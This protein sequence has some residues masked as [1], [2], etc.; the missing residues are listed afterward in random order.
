MQTMTLLAVAV[1]TVGC[2]ASTRGGGGGGGSEGPAE[3]EGEGPAEG[4]GEGE[5]PAEGEGEGEGP[6]EGEGAFGAGCAGPGDCASG[7]C[8][9]SAGGVCTAPCPPCPEGWHCGLARLVGVQG[10]P[11]RVCWPDPDPACAP[12]MQDSNCGG[13]G[14]RCLALPGGAYC[15]WPCGEADGCPEGYACTPTGDGR[16]CVP[17]HGGCCEDATPGKPETCNGLDDDCDGWVDDGLGPVP[18]DNVWGECAGNV[19]FCTGVGGW[20]DAAANYEPVAETCN[21]LDD[22]CDGEADEGCEGFAIQLAA[23][24]EHTCALLADGRVKCWGRNADGQLGLG[25]A[26]GRGVGAVPGEMGA[27]PALDLGAAL[28]AV[29]LGPGETATALAAAGGHT[30]A[31]L[32]DGRVKC[33]PYA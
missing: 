11:H 25:D 16:A 10:E 20:Q 22:D 3:G 29:D 13:G 5:G 17:E 26:V 31:L 19:R 18:A 21:G 2:G 27:L 24:G 15:A 1:L 9:T 28:P 32:E 12:C 4:E 33:W 6:A 8:T 7:L 23:A 30:C 14:R